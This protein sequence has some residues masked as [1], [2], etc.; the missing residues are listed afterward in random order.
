MG[1][2]NKAGLYIYIHT[3]DEMPQS[4]QRGNDIGLRADKGQESSHGAE[5][6]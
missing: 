3:Q 4:K 5:R 1:Y 2:S 6:C